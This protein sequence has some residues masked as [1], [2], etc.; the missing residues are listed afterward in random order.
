MEFK[1][2]LV[3]FLCI[4]NKEWISTNGARKLDFHLQ[5]KEV[6]SLTYT[7]YKNNSKWIKDLNIRDKT[8]KC[9]DKN[10]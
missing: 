7:V 9:L 5:K 4:T 1:D 10:R 6:G 3:E 8:I 2:C